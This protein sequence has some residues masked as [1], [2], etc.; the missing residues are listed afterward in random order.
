MHLLLNF[1]VLLATVSVAECFLPARGLSLAQRHSMINNEEYTDLCKLPRKELQQLA[2]ANGIKAN[3]KNDD[4]IAGLLAMKEAT[5]SPPSTS[6]TGD[7]K[8]KKLK[9]KNNAA[10]LEV[11][12]DSDIQSIL[13]M[14]GIRLDDL[15]DLRDQLLAEE[16]TATGKGLG[17]DSNTRSRKRGGAVVENDSNTKTGKATAK[18]K[19]AKPTPKPKS[20]PKVTADRA[21]LE[22][23]MTK[24]DSMPK[25]LSTRDWSPGAL[26]KTNRSPFGAVPLEKEPV[27]SPKPKVERVEAKTSRDPVPKKGLGEVTMKVYLNWATR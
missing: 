15:V 7:E 14:Q 12:S 20:K 18:E 25:P 13:N 4:I 16:E 8:S 3:M 10:N 26:I 27:G 24:D 6:S 5:T 1:F 17:S 22:K 21:S 23:S 2:K 19:T 9:K 11:K